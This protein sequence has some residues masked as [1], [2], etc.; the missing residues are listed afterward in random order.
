MSPVVFFEEGYYKGTQVRFKN[1]LIVGSGDIANLK[2]YEEDI[3]PLHAAFIK[4]NDG[5]YIT[6]LD[7]NNH[8][9]LNGKLVQNSRLNSGDII[10][11]SKNCILKFVLE[12]GEVP[13][14]IPLPKNNTDKQKFL[15]SENMFVKYERLQ[16]EIIH[17]KKQSKLSHILTL[18]AWVAI[19]LSILITSFITGIYITD[20]IL[21]A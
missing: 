3:A 9:T 20:F 18:V 16:Q 12:D 19:I 5:F 15:N 21:K 1:L 4:G 6:N 14:S 11:I 10:G 17:D 2:L 8:I 13:E 7:E